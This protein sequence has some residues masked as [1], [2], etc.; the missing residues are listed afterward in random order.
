VDDDAA[1]AGLFLRGV[2]QRVI[3]HG[4]Y[5]MPDVIFVARWNGQANTQD[6]VFHGGEWTP[7]RRIHQYLGNVTRTYGGVSILVDEDYLNVKLTKPTGTAAPARALIEPSGTHEAFYRGT[8]NG[9]WHVRQKPGR[10]NWTSP[11]SLGGSLDSQPSAVLAPNGG[12]V[13]FYRG[14]DGLLWQVS[15]HTGGWSRPRSLPQIGVLGGRPWAVSDASGTIDVFW[16][17]YPRST[18]WYAQHTPGLGW[19]KPHQ[20][21]SGLDSAPS[22]VISSPGVVKVFW[23]GQAGNLW[24]VTRNQ[25]GQWGR[26]A[27]LGM[28][29][30]GG[31][32]HATARPAG[33]VEVFWRHQG[34]ILSAFLPASGHWSGPFSLGGETSQ[35]PPVPV[36][37]GKLV[38]VLFVGSDG[39]LW[40]SVR[41]DTQQWH[42]PSPLLPGPLTSTPFA[43]IRPNKTRIDVFWKDASDQLWW[44]RVSSGGHA[45]TPRVVGDNAG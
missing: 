14:A 1:L 33:E 41:T 42:G 24:Q 2:L 37:A 8:D 22:P 3:R 35:S 13:V 36:S 10:R 34:G 38:H 32:P 43:G 21:A 11:A 23:K 7:H 19:S 12:R 25:A 20:L 4:K 45:S 18:L 28:G 17:N 16:R 30:L 26:P 31:W 6:D 44:A 15:S 27:G 29:P 5:A 39:E 9:L 40:Q